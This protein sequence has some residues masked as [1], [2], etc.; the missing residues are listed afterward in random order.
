MDFLVSFD[1]DNDKSTYTQSGYILLYIKYVNKN[2][3]LN[4]L[5]RWI[6]MKQD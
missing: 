3:F 5:N 1:G 6:Y 2:R 4:A